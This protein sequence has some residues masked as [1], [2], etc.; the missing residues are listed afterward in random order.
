MILVSD[1]R[2]CLS[3]HEIKTGFYWATVSEGQLLEN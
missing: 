2:T 3:E 1:A